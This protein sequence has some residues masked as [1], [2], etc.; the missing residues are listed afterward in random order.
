[1]PR[2]VLI[3]G[4]ARRIGAACTQWLHERGW[5]IVLHYRESADEAQAL[6]EQLNQKRS[7]SVRL[8]QADLRD[9]HQIRA[10]AAYAA[11]SWGGV[12]ALINNASSFYP[13]SFA[14]VTA[15]DWG[16]LIDA[17]VK[18]PFFLIQALLPTLKDRSGCVVNMVDIH[19]EAGLPGY[20]VYSLGKAA[21][22]NMTRC[23]AKELAPQI[24]VNGVAP[25][26][27]LWPEHEAEDY[28]KQILQKIPLQ[29]CGDVSDIAR[30]VCFLIEDAPY[31]TG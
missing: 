23:L 15:Q 3:T 31:V 29:R 7:D 26:A 10:L 12:S 28:Q 14:E 16:N 13:Q 6:A 9:L 24:R 27:I 21:L 17:N 18:A 2:S 5:N 8:Y 1:M 22:V 25:G 30:A 20:S 4:A 11:E 19:A